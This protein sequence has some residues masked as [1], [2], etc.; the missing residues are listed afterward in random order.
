MKRSMFFALCVLALSACALPQAQ[1]YRVRQSQ[2]QSR[3]EYLRYCN[4]Y[5]MHRPDICID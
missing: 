5:W 4:H 2:F 3:L 1:P